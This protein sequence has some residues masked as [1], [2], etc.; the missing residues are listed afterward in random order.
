MVRKKL[1]TSWISENNLMIIQCCLAIPKNVSNPTIY[2]LWGLRI[3]VNIVTHQINCYRSCSIRSIDK[4]ELSG[5]RT[6]ESCACM[7]ELLHVGKVLKF[8]N[9]IRLVYRTAGKAWRSCRLIM[10]LTT[11]ETV[12]IITNYDDVQVHLTFKLANKI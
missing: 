4:S 5:A 6:L 10:R 7:K 3:I 8:L 2:S 1:S 9:Q 11:T 12:K